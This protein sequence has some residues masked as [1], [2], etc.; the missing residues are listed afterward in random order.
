M[1]EI[2]VVGDGAGLVTSV[3]PRPEPAIPNDFALYPNYPNPF[4]P[5]TTF[6][7][8][9]PKAEYVTIKIYSITGEKV[10]TLV[11]GQVS[12]GLHELLESTSVRCEL[13][14]SATY[15]K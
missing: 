11:E 4:N 1:R 3:R 14:N 5:S 13:A 10:E 9:L 8:H 7:F 6:K 15:G 2:E 12:Q